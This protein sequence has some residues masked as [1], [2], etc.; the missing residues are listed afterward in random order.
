[1]IGKKE[2]HIR[3]NVFATTDGRHSLLSI[4]GQPAAV[5]SDFETYPLTKK[6]GCERRRL[7][8]A[9]VRFERQQARNDDRQTKR[10]MQQPAV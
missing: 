7:L 5:R 9:V 3:L 1:M 8:A 2:E 10:S 4:V 6:Y